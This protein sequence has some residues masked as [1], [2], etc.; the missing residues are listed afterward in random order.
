MWP[1]GTCGREFDAGWDGGFEARDQHCRA[2]GH[3][4]P[5]FERNYAYECSCCDGRFKTDAKR[6]DHEHSD[7]LYCAECDR[8]FDNWNNIQQHLNSSRHRASGI[9]CPFCK[10]TCRTATGL[11]H[12]LERGGCPN[13]PLDRD[14]LYRAV[15]ERDPQGIISNKFLEWYGSRT[16]EATEMSFNTNLNAYECYL[17]HRLFDALTSLNAHLSSP[18]HQ[19]NLYHCPSRSCHKEFTTL[20]GLINHLESESCGYIRFQAVQ[21]GIHHLVSSSTDHLVREV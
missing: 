7:H 11:T 21:N 5:H 15:R 13:A 14:R 19:Q 6:K 12:H 18:R 10:K 17:C 16:F 9:Q 4:I 2:L 8:D 20:A 3:S 1:C